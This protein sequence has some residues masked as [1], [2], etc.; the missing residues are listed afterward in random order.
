MVHKTRRSYSLG[1]E[2]VSSDPMDLLKNREILDP[3]SQTIM[4]RTSK[5][6]VFIDYKNTLV[7]QQSN[8]T[9]LWAQNRRSSTYL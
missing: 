5:Q 7:N 3:G 1:I 9:K 2:K 4:E 6:K 8:W